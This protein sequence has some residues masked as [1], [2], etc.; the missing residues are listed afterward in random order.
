ML[1]VSPLFV[2]GNRSEGFAKAA[3]SGADAVINDLEHDP[4]KLASSAVPIGWPR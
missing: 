1:P 4:E 2:P 3:A